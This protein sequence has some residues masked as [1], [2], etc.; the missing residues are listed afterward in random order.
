MQKN[1]TPIAYT[2]DR[3]RD[4][5]GPKRAHPKSAEGALSQQLLDSIRSKKYRPNS[6][7][8]LKKPIADDKSTGGELQF[9]ERIAKVGLAVNAGRLST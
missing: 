5:F 7:I 6:T 9:T 3:Q 8:D 1:K 4:V 2:C